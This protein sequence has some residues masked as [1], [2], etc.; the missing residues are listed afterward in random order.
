MVHAYI[1][2]YLP[3]NTLIWCFMLCF[4]SYKHVM[5]LDARHLF[6]SIHIDINNYYCVQIMYEQQ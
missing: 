4:F 2:L 5:K 3:T 6:K 1:H